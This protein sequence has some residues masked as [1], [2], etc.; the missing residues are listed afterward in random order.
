MGS[1]NANCRIDG[2]AGER[3]TTVVDGFNLGAATPPPAAPDADAEAEEVAAEVPEGPVS[4]AP[5]A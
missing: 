4:L 3:D 2:A 5:V 1:R